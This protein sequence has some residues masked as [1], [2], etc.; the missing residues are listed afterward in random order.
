[1]IRPNLLPIGLSSIIGLL[2]VLVMTQPLPAQSV[3]TPTDYPYPSPTIDTIPTASIESTVTATASDIDPSSTITTTPTPTTLTIVPLL[4]QPMN[5]VDVPVQPATP[6]TEESAT[7]EPAQFA[8]EPLRCSPNSVNLLS[9]H[10]TPDTQLLLKF[11]TRVVGG[12][13]SDST[14]F[15]AIPLKMG[16][17]PQGDYTISVVTR[18]K[19][20]VV[21][22]LPCLVP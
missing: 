13:S 6:N 18:A 22:T 9:G 8:P 12:G 10:T 4:L 20:V 5:N 11:G 7:P 14:G 1:M 21:A 3:A 17:E 15:F 16:K 2:V 19:S